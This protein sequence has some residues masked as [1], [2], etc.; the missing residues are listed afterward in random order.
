MSIC[1]PSIPRVLQDRPFVYG[2][3]RKQVVKSDRIQHLRHFCDTY[4][5]TGLPVG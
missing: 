2:M 5:P 1:Q 4:A 3:A